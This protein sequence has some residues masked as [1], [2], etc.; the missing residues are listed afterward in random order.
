VDGVPENEKWGIV[1][2]HNAQRGLLKNE[3]GEDADIDTV[4]RYQGGER[5]LIIVSGTASDRESIRKKHDFILN[6][7][8]LNV[9]MS[10]MKK[11]LIVVASRAMF[12]VI[13]TDAEDY[14]D[15]LLW[16]GL[17]HEVG[18]DQGDQLWSGQLSDLTGED[19]EEGVEDAH[20]DVYSGS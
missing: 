2:P 10:R 7:N 4:E 5:D 19:P 12:E 14:E 8:R 17:Y 1:T 16:R 13:P 15:A 18:A 9:A 11:K 20:I 6:P 3:I